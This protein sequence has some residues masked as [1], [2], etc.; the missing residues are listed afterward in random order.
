MWLMTEVDASINSQT[1][2]HHDTFNHILLA[3]AQKPRRKTN[4]KQLH[5]FTGRYDSLMHFIAAT[6]NAAFK[7]DQF[8][9]HKS[10]HDF[11]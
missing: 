5:S 2:E 1:V 9:Y 6:L 10:N 4:I 11:H 8:L 3:Q 7:V